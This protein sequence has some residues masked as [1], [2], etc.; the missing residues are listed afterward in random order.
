MPHF[1]LKADKSSVVVEQSSRIVVAGDEVPR[2][3]ASTTQ[4]PRILSVET[5]EF[6]AAPIKRADI[7]DGSGESTGL[8]DTKPFM[9]EHQQQLNGVLSLFHRTDAHCGAAPASKGSSMFW[10]KHSREKHLCMLLVHHE[11]E[12]AVSFSTGSC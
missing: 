9:A 5:G 3:T 8:S 12:S 7:W 11:Q 1:S 6:A 2:A 4:F 10:G